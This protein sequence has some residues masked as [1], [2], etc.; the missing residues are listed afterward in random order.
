M[1]KAINPLDPLDGEEST[2]A[3]RPTAVPNEA[4]DDDQ[5]DRISASI[6]GARAGQLREMAKEL[7]TSPR[8]LVEAILV[9][10][11]DLAP[12]IGHILEQQLEEKKQQ[13]AELKAKYK[14]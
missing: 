12:A 8:K 14:K 9:T 6:Y 11:E 3:A 4:T 5:D 2:A 10:T 1:V 13:I 7:K